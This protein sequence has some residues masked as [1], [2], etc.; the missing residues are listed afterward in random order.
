MSSPIP[1]GA[2][3]PVPATPRRRTGMIV[4]IILLSIALAAAAGALAWNLLQLQAATTTIDEQQVEIDQQRELIDERMTFGRAAGRLV[5]EA[6]SFAG[7]PYSA[8]V[9]WPRIER[10]VSGGWTSRW[11]IDVLPGQTTAAADAL[12]ELVALRAGARLEA[13]TNV[14]GTVYESVLD[15]LGQG[16]VRTSIDD[17]DALCEEDVLG[18]VSSA[19]PFNVHIDAA[20]TDLPHLTD[21]LRTGLAYHEYAHVLQFT[22]PEQTAIAVEAFGGDFETMA[23]CYTLTYLDGWTLTHRVPINRYSWWEVDMGY[24]HTC[25]ATQAQAVR[26]WI[27]TLGAPART[28]EHG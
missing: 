15:S 19:D 3:P 17:A 14:S 8:V 23:D 25:D 5:S 12:V 1:P 6:N 10:I 24:G 28:L 9:D 27:G 26:D 4:T 20:D 16:F 2:Y 18:C 13:S 11:N 7:L 22:N 21:W